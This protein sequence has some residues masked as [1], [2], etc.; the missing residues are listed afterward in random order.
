[1]STGLKPE[2]QLFASFGQ[3]IFT[4]ADVNS[5]SEPDHH[6]DNSSSVKSQSEH[7]SSS[8]KVDTQV[9]ISFCRYQPVVITKDTFEV[10]RD[11]PRFIMKKGHAEDPTTQDLVPSLPRYGLL[12]QKRTMI[13]KNN[14]YDYNNLRA[15]KAQQSS[16]INQANLKDQKG[17]KKD[18]E[19]YDVPL[20]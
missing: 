12:L 3:H 15:Q 18:S 5:A 19:Y 4:I 17:A 13:E 6:H 9:D 8:I 11:Q 2:V 20:I 14:S 7:G 1:M 10:S 16:L